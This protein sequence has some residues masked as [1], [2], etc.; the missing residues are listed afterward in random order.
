MGAESI[1]QGSVGHAQ[2]TI[3][4][5]FEFARADGKLPPNDSLVVIF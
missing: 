5:E 3:G 1:C 4:F 2:S